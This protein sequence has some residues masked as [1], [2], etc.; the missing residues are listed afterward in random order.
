MLVIETTTP[1]PPPKRV[2]RIEECYLPQWQI[3]N[4]NPSMGARLEVT[5]KKSIEA[6]IIREGLRGEVSLSDSTQKRYQPDIIVDVTGP[7]QAAHF[8]VDCR[9]WTGTSARYGRI[10][11]SRE[12][13]A[14]ARGGPT[15]DIFLEDDSRTL[16]VAFELAIVDSRGHR[17]RRLFL[18][19]GRWLRD[20]FDTMTGVP[21]DNIPESWPGFRKRADLLYDIDIRTLIAGTGGQA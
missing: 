2:A 3:C 9:H 14:T 13:Y 19:T 4:L 12:F 5:V 11:L 20:Q 18:P 16:F 17:E 7:G 8:S 21:I 6:A 1:T 15:L 10:Y